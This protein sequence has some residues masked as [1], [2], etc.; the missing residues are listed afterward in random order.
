MTARI[1]RCGRLLFG[2]FA[3]VLLQNKDYVKS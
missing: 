1:S 3:A 2:A